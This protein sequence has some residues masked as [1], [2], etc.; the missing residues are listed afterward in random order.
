MYMV[1]PQ[2]TTHAECCLLFSGYV[3]PLN[4]ITRA[5]AQN[6]DK[7]KRKIHEENEIEATPSGLNVMKK[8][9]ETWKA[10]RERRVASKKRKAERKRENNQL[11]HRTFIGLVGAEKLYSRAA[12]HRQNISLCWNN[13]IPVMQHHT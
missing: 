5:Q 1:Q 10:R 3:V 8:S 12:K 4:A 9:N 6:A 11:E 13:V 7:G 2:E